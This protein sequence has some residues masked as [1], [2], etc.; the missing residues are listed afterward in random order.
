MSGAGGR[1]VTREYLT[2]SFAGLL[3]LK[4][5]FGQ[6]FAFYFCKSGFTD[7]I[8]CM[9]SVSVLAKYK[10]SG[11]IC[12]TYT[13]AECLRDIFTNV[14]SPAK[15]IKMKFHKCKIKRTVLVSMYDIARGKECIYNTFPACS[16]IQ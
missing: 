10:Q 11:T 8:N 14:K 12:M 4:V 16:L 9:H 13:G 6:K 1:G 3:F 2:I 5:V 7:Y 15:F